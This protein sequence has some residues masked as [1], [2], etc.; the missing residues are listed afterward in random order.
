M[1]AEVGNFEQMEDQLRKWG[2]RL[3]V[4][5][6][7]AEREDDSGKQAVL[8]R[9]KALRQRK[10]RATVRLAALKAAPYDAPNWQDLRI[11][12]EEAYLQL[13]QAMQNMR[14]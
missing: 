10:A 11:E 12:A 3:A 5:A 4:L 2:S 7:R 8:N 1:Q 9:I 6:K 13:G 14:G